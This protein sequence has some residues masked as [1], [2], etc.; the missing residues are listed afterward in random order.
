MKTDHKAPGCVVFFV[1]ITWITVIKLSGYESKPLDMSTETFLQQIQNSSVVIMPRLSAGRS[2]LKIS[3]G[4]KES[5]PERPDWFWGQ[6]NP[7]L[8]RHWRLFPWR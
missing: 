8:Y 2:G 7:Q 6:N 4:A 3:G 5:S 1:W